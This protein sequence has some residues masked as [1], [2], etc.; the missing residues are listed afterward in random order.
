M[1]MLNYFSTSYI[2]IYIY[3]PQ[4]FLGASFF[5]QGHSALNPSLLGFGVSFV[6]FAV[7]VF[8]KT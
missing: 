8:Y 3:T 5:S 4:D 1:C 7:W 6:V 2:Y